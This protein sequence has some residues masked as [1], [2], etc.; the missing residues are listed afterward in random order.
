MV[1]DRVLKVNGWILQMEQERGV[2]FGNQNLEWYLDQ[3]LEWHWEKH[4][5]TN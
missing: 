3:Y 2:D 1:L 5:E 4:R